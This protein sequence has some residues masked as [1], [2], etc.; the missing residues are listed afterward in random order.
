MALLKTSLSVTILK[1]I[2]FLSIFSF[3][4][5]QCL[6]S[7]RNMFFSSGSLVIP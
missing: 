5:P 4:L 2:P 3:M 6:F 1:D 7:M